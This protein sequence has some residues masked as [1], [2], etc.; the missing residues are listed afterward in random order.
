[1]GWLGLRGI[2][3]DDSGKSPQIG[4]DG[5]ALLAAVKAYL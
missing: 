1:V 5:L 2:L 4:H 3:T